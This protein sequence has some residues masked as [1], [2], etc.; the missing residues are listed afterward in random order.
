MNDSVEMAQ[1]GAPPSGDSRFGRL[2][3]VMKRLHFAQ[4]A[5]IEVLH[6][7][8]EMFG[9]LD[10]GLLR[11]IAHQLKLPPSRVYG[12]ATFYHF[13][14]LTP[15]GQHQCVVCTG[16]ACHVQGADRLLQGAQEIAQIRP[17]ETTADNRFSLLTARCLGA[18]GAAP[19]VVFDG[20]LHGC[21][22]PELVRKWTSRV[23]NA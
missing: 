18:C 2:E 1:P 19:L 5:L 8:Q 6:V 4:H 10:V 3:D 7:A 16:T 23:L 15:K 11:F 22:T 14:T 13:F 20:D 21:Q 9:C 12:T 17:G